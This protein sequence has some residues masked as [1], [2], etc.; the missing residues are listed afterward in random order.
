MII[1]SKW[2]ENEPKLYKKELKYQKEQNEP[3]EHSQI[4]LYNLEDVAQMIKF[5]HQ[6]CNLWL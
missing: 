1:T 4:D 5:S 6:L 2:I 3:H